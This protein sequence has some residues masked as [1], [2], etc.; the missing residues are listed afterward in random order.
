MPDDL[1]LEYETTTVVRFAREG[2][3]TLYPPFSVRVISS[4][5][6]KSS[7]NTT[8]PD[9]KPD[10]GKRTLTEKPRN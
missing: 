1:V 4:T 8:V 10:G 7:V 9:G 5:R 6:A 2:R 3:P